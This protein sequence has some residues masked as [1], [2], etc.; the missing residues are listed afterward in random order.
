MPFQKG[1]SGNPAGRP[2]KGYALTELLEK[3]LNKTS[4]DIDGKRRANKR[5]LARAA[6][7]AATTGSVTFAKVSLSGELLSVTVKLDPR[8]WIT[9]AKYIIDRVDGPAKQRFDV[10]TD[11]ESLNDGNRITEGRRDA[12]VDAIFERARE[13]ADSENGAQE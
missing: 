11:D 9:W 8:D 7:E 13:R 4:L 1:Q 2:R 6:I 12:L 10:T 5:I 3:Q